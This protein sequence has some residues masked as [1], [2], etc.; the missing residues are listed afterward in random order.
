MDTTKSMLVIIAICAGVLLI[1]VLRQKA[2]M[3]LNFI[4]RTV[5]GVMGIYGINLLLAQMGIAA[6][7][8][9]NIISVLT[10]GTLGTGGI[11]LLYGILFYNML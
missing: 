5:L 1:G 2:E 3:I 8:G 7:V 4:V 6:A 9:I 10:V 11:G